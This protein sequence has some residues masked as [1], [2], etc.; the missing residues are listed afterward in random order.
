MG[1]EGKVSARARREGGGS[2]ESPCAQ[3]GPGG[4]GP[5]ARGGG[6]QRLAAGPRLLTPAPG[7][8]RPACDSQLLVEPGL[9]AGLEVAD[10]NAELPDVLHELLQVLL[11]VVELLRHHR[12]TRKTAAGVVLPHRFLLPSGPAATSAS[13]GGRMGRGLSGGAGPSGWGLTSRRG[14]GRGLIAGRGGVSSVPPQHP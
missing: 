3:P 4:T 11:Q 12:A 2:G 7:R 5:R 10:D 13:S 8:H 6:R 14:M 9:A 1:P